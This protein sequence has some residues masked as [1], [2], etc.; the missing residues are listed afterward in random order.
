[1]KKKLYILIKILLVLFFLSFSRP[2]QVKKD[3]KKSKRIKFIVLLLKNQ[4]S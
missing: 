1:M 4:H 2:M 3:K